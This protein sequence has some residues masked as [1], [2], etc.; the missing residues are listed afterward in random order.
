MSEFDY[1]ISEKYGADKPRY[2]ILREHFKDWY[3]YSVIVDDLGTLAHIEM[4]E[5]D[6]TMFALRWA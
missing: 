3:N 1:R 5:E 4:T 2:A 6:F